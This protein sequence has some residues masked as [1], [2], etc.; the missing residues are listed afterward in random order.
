MLEEEKQY[1]RLGM[2]KGEKKLFVNGCF[3]GAKASPEEE[4]AGLQALVHVRRPSVLRTWD[5][6]CEK[7]PY[8]VWAAASGGLAA[9]VQA[10]GARSRRCSLCQLPA[11]LASAR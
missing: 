9:A 7:G 1:Q 3:L 6:Y 10:G 4:A 11:P 8:S 2:M 5:R